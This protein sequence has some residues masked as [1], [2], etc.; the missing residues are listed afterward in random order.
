MLQKAKEVLS[1]PSARADTEAARK[2][3][4]QRAKGLA[5]SIQK[6]RKVFHALS[7]RAEGVRIRTDTLQLEAK[8]PVRAH[9]LPLCVT[10]C[11]KGV[12]TDT[13]VLRLV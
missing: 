2:D 11:I 5:E 3:L 12:V 7:E 13:C 10:V 8:R 6:W 4:T 1:A 9:V